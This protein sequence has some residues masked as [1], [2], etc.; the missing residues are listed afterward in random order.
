PVAT[1][2]GEAAPTPASCS[3]LS[4]RNL[5]HCMGV[6]LHWLPTVL[7]EQRYGHMLVGLPNHHVILSPPLIGRPSTDS[8]VHAM[9]G[10]GGGN[11]RISAK[12]RQGSVPL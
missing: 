5:A 6:S 7:A 2:T 10:K 11:G 1:V 12:G 9:A 8:A 4:G 3:R